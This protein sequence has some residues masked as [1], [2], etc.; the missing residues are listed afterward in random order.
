MVIILRRLGIV[1]RAIVMADPG[2]EHPDTWAHV[3]DVMRPWLAEQGMPDI[4]IIRRADECRVTHREDLYEQCARLA[5]LPSA[6][7]GRGRC[8]QHFKADP[9]IA[10]VKR[11]PWMN[12]RLDRARGWRKVAQPLAGG[13]WTNRGVRTDA[14]LRKQWGEIEPLRLHVA[15]GY[16]AGEPNRAIPEFRTKTEPE[17]SKPWY[18]LLERG[19]DRDSCTALILS[20]G[21][22]LPTKSACTFCPHQQPAEWALLSLH[23]PEAFQR[24]L[25]MERRALPNLTSP[26]A[27]L[28]WRA[29][30][31]LPRRLVDLVQHPEWPRMLER[32]ARGEYDEDE[33]ES[34][35]CACA[36]Q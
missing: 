28:V 9:F 33:F 3:H 6:A 35:P 20:E 17:M 13:G 11:Q 4:T 14:E 18:P 25:V 26:T 21:L 8:A 16:D 27:G 2:A 29:S 30:R 15:I 24:A 5:T 31:G 36:V 34:M 22:P 7:F 32:A 19:H 1:P 23:Q 10:W 12:E